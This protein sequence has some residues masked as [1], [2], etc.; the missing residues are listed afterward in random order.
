MAGKNATMMGTNFLAELI[1][2]LGVP[3]DKALQLVHRGCERTT[4]F[5]ASDINRVLKE[6]QDVCR[7]GF[8]VSANQRSRLERSLWLSLAAIGCDLESALLPEVGVP[9]KALD[10]AARSQVFDALLLL[11]DVVNGNGKKGSNVASVVGFFSYELLATLVETVF[12]MLRV[13]LR[14]NSGPTS[15]AK[16]LNR[17]LNKLLTLVESTRVVSLKNNTK[18]SGAKDNISPPSVG[19]EDSSASKDPKQEEMHSKA[20]ELLA[21][22][23]K[24]KLE[25]RKRRPQDSTPLA[26][27]N[28][29]DEDDDLPDHKILDPFAID[30]SPD[31]LSAALLFACHDFLVDVVATSTT[32]RGNRGTRGGQEINSN[33]TLLLSGVVVNRLEALFAKLALND[34]RGAT[35]AVARSSLALLTWCGVKLAPTSAGEGAEMALWPSR[36]L[37]PDAAA[38]SSGQLAEE[39]LLEQLLADALDLAEHQCRELQHCREKSAD[40]PRGTGGVFAKKNSEVLAEMGEQ[41]KTLA[42]KAGG[43]VTA[44]IGKG[45]NLLEKT[46]L[47]KVDALSEYQNLKFQ[48][49]CEEMEDL[50]ESRAEGLVLLLVELLKKGGMPLKHYPA[51]AALGKH[52]GEENCK[53]VIDKAKAS[54]RPFILDVD[55]E[56][57]VAFFDEFLLPL[58]RQEQAAAPQRHHPRLTKSLLQ[59]VSVVIEFLGTDTLIGGWIQQ[60]LLPALLNPPLQN[61]DTS[62]AVVEYGLLTLLEKFPSLFLDADVVKTCG[63]T[64]L[65]LL[66]GLQDALDAQ[67]RTTSAEPAAKRRRKNKASSANNLPSTPAFPVRLCADGTADF[68]RFYTLLAQTVGVHLVG[69]TMLSAVHEEALFVVARGLSSAANL[70]TLLTRSFCDAILGLFGFTMFDRRADS[71]CGGNVVEQSPAGSSS[72]AFCSLSDRVAELRTQKQF[73]PP[74]EASIPVENLNLQTLTKLEKEF[75]ALFAGICDLLVE[76]HTDA[77]V[78]RRAAVLRRRAGDPDLMETAD[79]QNFLKSYMKNRQALA[80]NR[81][82]GATR[83]LEDQMSSENA[84][85]HSKK[86]TRQDV[87]MMEKKMDILEEQNSRL[88]AELAECAAE[89]AAELAAETKQNNGEDG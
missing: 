28:V 85:E 42:E 10:A 43:G 18:T 1:P 49:L 88:V 12:K 36:D 67:E 9:P 35:G 65:K 5:T 24:Q 86:R 41:A 17:S 37:D 71:I 80:E 27:N 84:S 47:A 48:L 76:R 78:V 39:P 25:Q 55:L 74:L 79:T 70:E 30:A 21:L 8:S 61:P 45:A 82:R 54:S 63:Q 13:S 69:T 20:K 51:R 59:L 40:A 72:A 66:Q 57:F 3:L 4:I 68:L 29:A 50:H 15:D 56:Q 7:S 31:G 26:E 16:K 73:F 81:E 75:Q 53:K 46:A 89:K 62:Q 2:D 34:A 38:A 58:L 11:V 14:E 77:C 52:L 19:E 87:E 33:K 83:L 23:R 60:K 32:Q 22:V 6:F 44:G 64:M